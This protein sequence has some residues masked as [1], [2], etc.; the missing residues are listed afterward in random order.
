M[1]KDIKTK[2]RFVELRA[3]G[4]SFAKIALE[5]GV[6]KPTLIEWA[7]DEELQRQIKN[8]QAIELEALQEKYYARKVQRLELLGEQAEAVKEELKKRSLGDVPT[9]KLL[10]LLLKLSAAL[11]EEEKAP[12]FQGE[13]RVQDI[14]ELLGNMNTVTPTWAA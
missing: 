1:A 12:V 7:K 5:L 10:G 4:L 6:S 9:D 8:L 14:D 13:R 11:K 3:Q 2:E